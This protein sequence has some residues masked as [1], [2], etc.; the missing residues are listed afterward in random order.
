MK[1]PYTK[2]FEATVL[3]VNGNQVIL[4]KTAFFAE[5]GGQIGDTGYLNIT[6][7]IDTKYDENKENVIHI[8]EGEPDFRE[9]DKVIGI[10]DWDRR[11]KIMKNHAASH[12]MEHFLFKIFGELRLIGTS[13]SEKH[14]SST[15]AYSEL[16][17]QN[18][19]KEVERL[20]NEFIL[21]D[22]EIKRWEDPNKP[23]WWYWES[24]EIIMP[25]GG[26]HP[27]NTKE[28]GKVSIKRKGGGKGKEKILTSTI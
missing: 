14:D 28:I 17:D 2:E 5:S 15:Y 6:K 18:K 7:V 10:I 24:G 20:S 25:C 27:I 22:Y 26:T 21:K 13:V 8:I 19:L 16:F 4:D 9:R 11:Y 12:I 1:D 23:G 3:K